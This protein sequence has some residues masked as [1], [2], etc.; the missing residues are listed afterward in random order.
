MKILAGHTERDGVL[1]QDCEYKHSSPE[2]I[3]TKLL[4]DQVDYHIVCDHYQAEVLNTL[5]RRPIRW[6]S[7]F[8]DYIIYFNPEQDV[9]ERKKNVGGW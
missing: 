3:P 7:F 9:V 5:K 4:I 1:G 2:P 6:T 8:L